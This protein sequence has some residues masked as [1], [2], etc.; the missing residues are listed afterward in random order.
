[1]LRRRRPDAFDVA[2][3]VFL[4]EPDEFCEQSVGGDDTF[5]WRRAADQAEDT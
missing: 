5:C 1:M 3:E 4:E 2:V